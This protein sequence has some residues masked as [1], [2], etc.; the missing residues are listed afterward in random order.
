V[1]DAEA[2]GSTTLPR[3]CGC[4]RAAIDPRSPL[5]KWIRRLSRIPRMRS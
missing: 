3:L 1:L 2:N 5:A 4:V